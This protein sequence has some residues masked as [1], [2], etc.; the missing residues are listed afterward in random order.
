M[1]ASDLINRLQDGI[2]FVV[3]SLGVIIYCTQQ[4]K[5]SKDL[6][7]SVKICPPFG[8]NIGLHIIRSEIK[9]FVK[10]LKP[11]FGS[12]IGGSFHGL[13]FA[14]YSDNRLNSSLIFPMINLLKIIQLN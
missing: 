10:L 11:Y 4:N 7:N 6:I 12:R 8:L 13:G 1:K 5:R 9:C 2:L 14:F 3:L